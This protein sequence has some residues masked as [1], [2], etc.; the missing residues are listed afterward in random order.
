M[1]FGV[2]ITE[3]RDLHCSYIQNESYKGTTCQLKQ[4]ETISPN[5]ENDGYT[6]TGI[7][8]T[9]KPRFDKISFYHTNVSFVPREA[10]EEFPNLKYIGFKEVDMRR[11]DYNW[12]KEFLKFEK[13]IVGL[14]FNDLYINEIDPRAIEIFSKYKIINLKFNTC[15]NAYI[16]TE[17]MGEA[18]LNSKLQQCISN[19]RT[20][21]LEKSVVNIEENV[22]KMQSKLDEINEKLSKLMAEKL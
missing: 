20:R 7:D 8:I 22:N 15:V 4:K 5:T 18:G 1:S 13:N 10:F 12:L 9:E 6:F 17:Y 16:E 3:S 19:F 21:E 2:L 11:L 14:N